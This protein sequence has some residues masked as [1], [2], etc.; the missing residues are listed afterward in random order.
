MQV[1]YMVFQRI[2]FHHIEH[3]LENEHDLREHLAAYLN[4]F[5]ELKA[6]YAPYP[7][8][9]FYVASM[10]AIGNVLIVK[11]TGQ[12]DFPLDSKLLKS[13]LRLFSMLNDPKSKRNNDDIDLTDLIE[14]SFSINSH[15][16]YSQL[17]NNYFFLKLTFSSQKSFEFT[18]SDH[19]TSNTLYN[20][21]NVGF[22]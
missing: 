16:W 12:S 1:G 13:S 4:G 10:V 14:S 21:R 9:C 19:L 6:A 17:I 20:S 18:Q 7:D 5:D 2:Y 3:S 11:N 15:N 8:A 22:K